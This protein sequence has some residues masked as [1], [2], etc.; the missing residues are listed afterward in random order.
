M[1]VRRS[2]VEHS[3]KHSSQLR[4]YVHSAQ[5]TR[6]VFRA[7]VNGVSDLPEPEFPVQVCSVA[8]GVLLG[9]LVLLYMIPM[10]A[11]GFRGYCPAAVA[12]ILGLVASALLALFTGG[13]PAVLTG[14]L[15]TSLVIF[16]L[17]G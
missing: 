13:Y 7:P 4:F 11:V 5:A 2:L 15:P 10:I 8:G 17:G 12:V 1:L 3:R 9:T 6:V 16:V 14:I